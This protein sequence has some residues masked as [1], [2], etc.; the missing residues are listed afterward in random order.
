MS[1]SKLGRNLI[2]NLFSQLYVALIGVLIIPF[3]LQ[4]MGPEAYGLVML[5]SAMIVWFS[6]LDM[7]IVS[8]ISRQTSCY[9]VGTISISLYRSI[10][11]FFSL[12]VI[13][14]AFIAAIALWG[15]AGWLASN[16][17]R[18]EDLSNTTV[19]SVFQLIAMIVVLRWCCGLYRGVL[20]GAEEIRWL[21]IYNILIASI[22]FIGVLPFIYF[23][24]NV[25][26]FF[27]FQLV[28]AL[29]ELGWI[30]F[31]ARPFLP[32]F[33]LRSWQCHRVEIRQILKFSAIIALTTV[34]WILVSQIDRFIVSKTLDLSEF[35]FFATAVTVAAVINMVSA[36][37]GTV[38]M[39]RLTHLHETDNQQ[40]LSL[41]YRQSTQLVV[42]LSS[43]IAM[44]CCFA[45]EHILFA[46]TGNSDLV[47][48]MSEVLACYALG[49]LLLAVSA[50]PYY[51][52]FAR[53]KL[54]FHLWGHF[55]LL[56]LLIPGMYFSIGIAGAIGAAYCWLVVQ[57]LY[58][59]FWLPYVHSQLL[60]GFHIGWLWHDVFKIVFPVFSI[61]FIFS[62][63]VPVSDDRW[64]AFCSVL[65]LGFLGVMTAAASSSLLRR[66][67]LSKFAR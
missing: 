16:W 62:L 60:P 22:R 48:Q 66:H 3:Y 65:G 41:A 10:F 56:V 64:V 34:V 36:T 43:I 21:S 23:V 61:G 38:L 19:T 13:S 44:V 27:K 63:F 52:Q 32:E 7:G 35:G 37:F 45:G 18:Y 53:G 40:E 31:L 20:T 11:S 59:V 51:L 30:Y 47:S 55:I 9:L 8:T 42:V 14:V 28:V 67:L 4:L 2:W 50:F 46:W 12:F 17:I 54:M 5:Y 25:E 58:F 33:Q 29:L 15:S 1:A 6:I 26:M 49:N 24:P 57:G 39:P